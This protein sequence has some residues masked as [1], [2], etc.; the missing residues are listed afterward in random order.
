[1]FRQ[2]RNDE[3]PVTGRGSWINS[4]QRTFPYRVST[5]LIEGGQE[6]GRFV[7]GRV[8]ELDAIKIGKLLLVP[9]VHLMFSAW[10]G[11][12]WS[13]LAWIEMMKMTGR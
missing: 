1:M 2:A 3:L 11:L 13:G 6:N 4:P 7:V 8:S 5:R 12:V 10:S 9:R